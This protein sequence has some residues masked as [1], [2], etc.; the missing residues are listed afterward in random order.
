MG[1]GVS[2]MLDPLCRGTSETTQ[3]RGHPHRDQ[4]FCGFTECTLLLAF[5]PWFVSPCGT[6]QMS[7]PQHTFLHSPQEKLMD[8]KC[9]K[10]L[11][12]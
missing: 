6:Q 2:E 7:L 4:V 9:F 11:H 10:G 5:Q 8:Q 3:G 1:E 12:T